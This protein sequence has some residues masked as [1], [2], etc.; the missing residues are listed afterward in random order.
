LAVLIR[1]PESVSTGN[2]ELAFSLAYGGAIKKMLSTTM[3]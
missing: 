2:E 1:R 3:L